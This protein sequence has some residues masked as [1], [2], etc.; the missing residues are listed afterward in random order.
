M[1]IP[2]EI[3]PKAYQ[4]SK[5]VYEGKLTLKEGTNYLSDD[6]KMNQSSARDY[7]YGFRYLIEG[8]KFS[9]TLNAYSMDYFFE[10]FIKDYGLPNLENPLSALMNAY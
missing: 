10:N 3:V 5:K 2:L 8:K 7:I 9:R 6:G 1:K 4:T